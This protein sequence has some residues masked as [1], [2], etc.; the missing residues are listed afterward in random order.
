MEK[1]RI[2]LGGHRG[3]R[4]H[5]PENTMSAMQA[6]AR[7]GADAIETDVRMTVMANWC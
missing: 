2:L 6:M 7:M 3:D 5:Y 1:P 4:A